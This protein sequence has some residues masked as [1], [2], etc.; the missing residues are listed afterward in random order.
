[1]FSKETALA[2]TYL[3]AALQYSEHG[4]AIMEGPPFFFSLWSVVR[5]GH[6]QCTGLIFDLL[7]RHNQTT[8]QLV[9]TST[10]TENF[11]GPVHKLPDWLSCFQRGHKCGR[12]FRSNLYG[13]HRITSDTAKRQLRF[14]LPFRKYP[15]IR[16][17]SK[18]GLQ[19]PFSETKKSGRAIRRHI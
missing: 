10:R 12:H 9:A 19:K 13:Q 8:F 15:E 4:N 6:P 5:K 18:H 1:V 11:F 17:D 14:N 7:M 3:Q 2:Y 16:H